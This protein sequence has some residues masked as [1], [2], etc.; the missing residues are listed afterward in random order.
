MDFLSFNLLL[1]HFQFRKKK[2]IFKFHFFG[3]HG[4]AELISQGSSHVQNVRSARI[5]ISKGDVT[6]QRQTTRENAVNE[7]SFE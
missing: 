5:K 2:S 4:W 3:H 6:M 7:L 1:F